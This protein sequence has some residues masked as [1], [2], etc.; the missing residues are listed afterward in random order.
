MAAAR[1]PRSPPPRWAR[2]RDRGHAC[3]RR[4]VVFDALREDV[5][6]AADFLD[7][8][9]E[10]ARP[11]ARVRVAKPVRSRDVATAVMRFPF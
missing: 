5:L 8:F 2:G 9:D 10:V 3:Y 11:V 7:F 4:D 6:R 1:V